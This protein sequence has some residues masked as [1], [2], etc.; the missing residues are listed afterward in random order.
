MTTALLALTAAFLSF[1]LFIY[2]VMESRRA[3]QSVKKIDEWFETGEQ[4]RKSFV[5]LI[6]DKYDESELSRDLGKKLV[7]A[8]I[9][10]KPSEYMGI[11]LLTLAVLWFVGFF[12]LGLLPLIAL[13]IAYFSV[14]IGSRLLL[15]ARQDKLNESFNKQLPE[16]C[17]MMS[18]SIKAGQ[19]IP[20]GIEMVGTEVSEPAGPQFKIMDQQIKLGD[21]VEQVMGRFRERYSSKEISIFV[22]TILIQRRVGGNLAEVLDLMAGTIEERGRVQKE[23]QTAT[24]ESRSIAYILVIMPFMMAIMMNL[25]IEGFLNVLFT[26]WG[27]LLFAIFSLIMF[28]AF[29]L[30]KRI[31]R[32][33]V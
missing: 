9:R 26:T 6:G 5:I 10:L 12:L 21:D 14:W 24:A 29:I 3:K 23:I 30:I 4:T 15:N 33:R 31:S 11:Y 25:F 2:Y 20:Q 19:T 17:R 22:S 13:L 28:A 1:F 8:N 7:K 32:I 27:L 16:I 18:N